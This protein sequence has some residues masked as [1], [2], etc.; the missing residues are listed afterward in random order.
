MNNTAILPRLDKKIRGTLHELR[1]EKYLNSRFGAIRDKAHWS[2]DQ[3]QK[4]IQNA[5]ASLISTINYFGK[6]KK[7]IDNIKDVEKKAVLQSQFRTRALSFVEMVE[8]DSR[9][10]FIEPIAKCQASVS[11]PSYPDSITGDAAPYFPNIIANTYGL[12]QHRLLTWSITGLV[13]FFTTLADSL[14]LAPKG[15]PAV[16]GPMAYITGIGSSTLLV[17][18]IGKFHGW[19][20]IRKKTQRTQDSLLEILKIANSNQI[21]LN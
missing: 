8:E 10:K 6:I 7:K 12:Q 11:L 19:D 14:F 16:F 13:A 2:F 5:N 15:A 18:T 17:Y 20:S 9:Y 3:R 4:T 21:E 1:F